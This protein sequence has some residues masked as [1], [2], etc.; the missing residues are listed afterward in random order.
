DKQRRALHDASASAAIDGRPLDRPRAG[1]QDQAVVSQRFLT[2]LSMPHPYPCLVPVFIGCQT[3]TTPTGT[4]SLLLAHAGSRQQQWWMSPPES[5]LHPESGPSH[6]TSNHG[7]R[8][9][10]HDARRPRLLHARARAPAS[11]PLE[12]PAA[13]ATTSAST[14]VAVVHALIALD[15]VAT[16]KLPVAETQGAG[17]KWRARQPVQLTSLRSTE[18]LHAQAW[19]T[20][21]AASWL[22]SYASTC[23]HTNKETFGARH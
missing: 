11:C 16:P 1:H 13:A 14:R 4:V 5:N 19:L 15:P 22:F 3:A 9:A 7:S 23:S 8:C 21:L 17:A 6:H 12:P 20:L 10:H 18:P 2:I